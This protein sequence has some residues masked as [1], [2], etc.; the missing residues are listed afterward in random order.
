MQRREFLQKAGLLTAQSVLATAVLESWFLPNARGE[1]LSLKSLKEAISP[2]DGFVLIPQDAQFAAYQSAFNRRTLRTPLVRVLCSTP[3]GVATAIQWAQTNAVPLAVRS[4]GHSFEG[5]S[6]GTGL[7]IDTR[8]MN[9]ILIAQDQQSFV[10]G[11]GWQLGGVYASLA[12]NQRAIPAGSCPT[13]G[14][15]GHTLGGGY[16]L[17]SRPFGL[18]CD[19]LLSATVVDAR[20]QILNCSENEN[21]DLFWALR[22]G[23]AGSFGIVTKLQFRTHKVPSVRT[24]GLR[25]QVPAPAAA[26]LMKA[27]QAWAPASPREITSI[28]NISRA[29]GGL[30]NVRFLGQS[31]GS[32]ESLR[33]ELKSMTGIIRSETPIT[34]QNLDFAQAVRHFGG[35]GKSNSVFMKGKS[36]YL[37]KTMSD[38]HLNLFLE[39]IPSGLAVM[40]DS[41]GGAIRDLND[42]ETAFPHRSGILSSLQY[43]CEWANAAEGPQKMAN[44]KRFH[45]E[46]RPAMSGRAYFNYCDLDLPNYAQAYWGK[47]LDRLIQIKRAYDPSN[48]F[49]HA[50]SIPVQQ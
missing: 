7:I 48:F 50:Q 24:Y 9:Q 15:T 44:L 32:E 10:L 5:L 33:K 11:A 2:K 23:G 12:K 17:L 31:I 14:I 49:S 38:E 47:N 46:M 26:R 35:S 8:P 29:G 27:W 40:F 41:Y 6:Q 21:S 19:N 43:Y 25:W 1:S 37:T 30:I 36:D 45:A 28:M 39:K 16:G 42:H 18:A 3:A 22:G 34:V 4:G 13:V 20:G